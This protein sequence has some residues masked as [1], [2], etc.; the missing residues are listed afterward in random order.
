M[1]FSSISNVEEVQSESRMEKMKSIWLALFDACDEYRIFSENG[2]ELSLLI[3]M[4]RFQNYGI[5]LFPGSNW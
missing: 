4:R 3:E 5:V 1:I 2:M